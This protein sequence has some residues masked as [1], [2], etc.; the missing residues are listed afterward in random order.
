MRSN[1]LPADITLYAGCANKLHV[2]VKDLGLL[3]HYAAHCSALYKCVRVQCTSAAKLQRV[4]GRR[5]LL[6]RQQQQQPLACLPRSP[7]PSLRQPWEGGGPCSPTDWLPQLQASAPTPPPPGDGGRP[8][9][10]AVF[11]EAVWVP[12]IAA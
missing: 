6:H 7:Q 10:L 11:P 8:R 5:W 3:L 2:F 4:S 12:Q 1:C 9:P